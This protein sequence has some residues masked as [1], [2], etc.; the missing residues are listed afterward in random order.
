MWHV[1][2]KKK[3]EEEE[4]SAQDQKTDHSFFSCGMLSVPLVIL[5]ICCIRPNYVLN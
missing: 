5:I 2:V 3:N 1:L 4:E